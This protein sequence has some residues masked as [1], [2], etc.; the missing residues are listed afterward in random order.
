MTE[1]Q[2]LLY[3]FKICLFTK[4]YTFN[5][6]NL[7]LR[8]GNC[9][10]FQRYYGTPLVNV[11]KYRLNELFYFTNKCDYS[12]HLSYFIPGKKMDKKE[13]YKCLLQFCMK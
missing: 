11:D 3:I 4:L 12:N 9:D 13:K 6:A 8:K 1:Q 5:L 7:E 2:Y 10:S